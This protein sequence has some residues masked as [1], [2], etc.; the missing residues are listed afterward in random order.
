MYNLFLTILNHSIWQ[1]ESSIEYNKVLPEHWEALCL[2]LQEQAMTSV[3]FNSFQFLP[4]E[5]RP[6]RNLYLKCAG[7]TNYVK[8]SNKRI[9]KAISGIYNLLEP[10]GIKPIVMK[11]LAFAMYYPIP[12]MRMSGDIDLFIPS[13]YDEVI[14]FLKD[15]GY[16]LEYSEKHYKFYFENVLIELHHN[17][18]NKPF[19]EIGYYTTET[20][21]YKNVK[22]VT[23]DL[24]TQALLIITHAASHQVGPGIGFRHLCDWVLFLKKNGSSLNY[25]VLN[26]EINKRHLKLFLSVFTTVANKLLESPIPVEIVR[27]ESKLVEKLT[28]DLFTQG[29]C[30]QSERKRR[31]KSNKLL[32]IIMYVRR[33][34]KFMPYSIY[35]TMYSLI[36]KA[37]EILLG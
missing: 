13:H 36:L 37:K 35:I 29:D 34:I 32:Y 17:V 22:F 26:K 7:I 27:N 21:E 20:V 31:M 25:S 3:C 4:T 1:K 2:L 28:N 14:Q 30:G 9:E 16:E 23:F 18:I 19:K 24:Q 8:V 33:L 5:C 10:I 6:P 12:E 15:K 11:G